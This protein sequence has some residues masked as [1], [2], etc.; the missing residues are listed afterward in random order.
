MVIASVRA[1]WGAMALG[2]VG[3]LLVLWGLSVGKYGIRT[4]FVV[5]TVWWVIV[6]ALASSVR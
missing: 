3:Y 1:F 6:A 4:N 2:L 5:T